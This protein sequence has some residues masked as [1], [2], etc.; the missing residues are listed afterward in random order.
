M[1][2]DW[3]EEDT[4]KLEEEAEKTENQETKECVWNDYYS[5]ITLVKLSDRKLIYRILCLIRDLG[6]INFRKLEK[7]LGWKYARITKIMD[8]Y[9]LLV[10][11]FGWY[12]LSYVSDACMSYLAKATLRIKER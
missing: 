1:Y 9:K 4:E 11:D 8:E 2:N 3:L 6:K 7:M 10:Y 5:Y 12:D